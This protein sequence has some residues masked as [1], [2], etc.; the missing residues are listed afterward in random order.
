MQR[1]HT[2]PTV[3]HLLYQLSYT[4]DVEIKIFSPLATKQEEIYDSHFTQMINALS[5]QNF[6][7]TK[8]VNNKSK[9]IVKEIGINFTYISIKMY[10]GEL[11]SRNCNE[12]RKVGTSVGLILKFIFHSSLSRLNQFHFQWGASDSMQVQ[13]K[14]GAVCQEKI[15]VI[16]QEMGD[17]LIIM[18]STI[19]MSQSVVCS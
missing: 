5:S 4:I 14:S 10:L 19:N 1:I 17:Q 7:G 6:G 18:N 9:S 11:E 12:C 15:G 3:L 16:L 2:S 8:F 13:V